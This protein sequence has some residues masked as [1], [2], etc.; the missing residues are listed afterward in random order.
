MSSSVQVEAVVAGLL[1]SKK[2]G[3][4]CETVVR[5]TVEQAVDLYCRK[6]EVEKAA[7]RKLHQ[8][9]G[10]YLQGAWLKELERATRSSDEIDDAE[11]F[12]RPLLRL[13]TSTRE[14]EE[15]VETIFKDL[16]GVI[17][18][19]RQVLDL[20]CGLNPLAFPWMELPSTTRYTAVDLHH[21]LI[22]VLSRCFGKMRWN[23][24]AVCGDVLSWDDFDADVVLMMKMLPCLV[25]QARD[26][27]LATVARIPAETVVVSYPS[28]SLSGSEKGMVE[29]YAQRVSKIADACS[30][31]IHVLECPSERF[32]VLKKRV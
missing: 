11:A 28:K 12:C 13:H 23:A 29:H 2:Y 10:A 26:G 16:F 24:E 1:S 17:G 27:D 15:D 9:Y 5:R 20:A 14:R 7:R 3:Q 30:R 21:G 8:A 32:Y 22:E 18:T 6:R 19:P 31:E 4:L 25:H